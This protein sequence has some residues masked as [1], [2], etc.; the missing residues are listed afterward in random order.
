[1][2]AIALLFA[3]PAARLGVGRV[4][5]V[6]FA[7]NGRRLA[8]P[9]P[10]RDRHGRESADAMAGAEPSIFSVGHSRSL[11]SI[12]LKYDPIGVIFQHDA[13]QPARPC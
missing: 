2:M 1:M 8:S 11:H 5:A 4:S 6:K 12:M 3:L 9:P 13:S 7:V 10:K